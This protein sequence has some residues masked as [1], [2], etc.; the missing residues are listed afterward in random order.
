MD[1][2]QNKWR[3]KE[4]IPKVD[5]LED[6]THRS[7]HDTM[8]I[9]SGVESSDLRYNGDEY[10]KFDVIE[11]QQYHHIKIILLSSDTSPFTM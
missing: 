11:D 2:K 1:A 6:N 5:I 9:P 8:N 3:R 7:K 10:D 4:R